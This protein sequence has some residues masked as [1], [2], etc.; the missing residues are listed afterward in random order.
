MRFSLR[1]ISLLVISTLFS[2]CNS[3]SHARKI[4]VFQAVISS[5]SLQ[6]LESL[7]ATFHE[8]LEL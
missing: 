7:S 2:V 1:M 8:E 5:D 6:L 3:P 4:A